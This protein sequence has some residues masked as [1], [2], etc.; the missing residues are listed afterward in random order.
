MG[1]ARQLEVVKL[2]SAARGSMGM[3]R[4]LEVVGLM[5]AA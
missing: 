1:V 2:M 3:V 4:Q 5:S